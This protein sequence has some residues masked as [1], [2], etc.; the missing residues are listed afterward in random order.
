[1]CGGCSRWIMKRE[2]GRVS[3]KVEDIDGG[4]GRCKNGE[5]EKEK[6]REE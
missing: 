3:G 2:C 5:G 1:M 6:K 4:G